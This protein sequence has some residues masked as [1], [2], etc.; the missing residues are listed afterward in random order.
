MRNGARVLSR[1]SLA[2][3][4]LVMVILSVPIG[5]LTPFVPV[6]LPIGIAGAALLA[7]NAVWGQRLVGWLLVR[8][9]KLER[10]SPNWLI[11]LILNRDKRPPR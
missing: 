9:P 10:I 4:G 8:Y 7:R 6:G 1:Q 3:L 2:I 11:R 5:F